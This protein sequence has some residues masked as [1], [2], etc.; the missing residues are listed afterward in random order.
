MQLENS[1][2]THSETWAFHCSP[3]GLGYVRARVFIGLHE[4]SKAVYPMDRVWYGTG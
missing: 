3:L 2:N 4:Y 1:F